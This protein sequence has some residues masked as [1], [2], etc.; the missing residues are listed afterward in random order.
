MPK[1]EEAT[2]PRPFELFGLQWQRQAHVSAAQWLEASE[3][4]SVR[5]QI[6]TILGLY[7]DPPREAFLAETPVEELDD[8]LADLWLAARMPPDEGNG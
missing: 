5:A 1:A 7:V 3:P 6:N 8:R 4:Q 2:L